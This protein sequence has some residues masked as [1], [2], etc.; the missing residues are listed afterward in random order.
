MSRITSVVLGASF[1]DEGKGKVVDWLCNKAA[2]DTYNRDVLV[3]RFSGGSQCGHT[4]VRNG[5]RHIHG[6]FP[7]GT[8]GAFKGYLTEDCVFSPYHAYNEYELLKEKVGGII[9]LQIHPLA[10]LNTHLDVAF[11]RVRE[12]ILGHGSCGMGVGAAMYRNEHTPYKFRV[13]DLLHP[14]V[15]TEKLVALEDFYRQE[16]AKFTEIGRDTLIKR[17]EDF[18]TEKKKALGRW[19]VPELVEWVRDAFTIAPLDLNNFKGHLIF[20]GSQGV[21]LDQGH[22]MFP[23]C[24]YANTTSKNIAKY[25]DEQTETYY[26]TRSYLTRHGNGPFP[27]ESKKIAKLVD[28]PTNKPNDWQGTQRYAGLDLSMLDHAFS[29]DGAYNPSLYKNIVVN[30]LD[31]I[32]YDIEA[33]QDGFKGYNIFTSS[34]PTSRAKD[35]ILRD[36]I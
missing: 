16:I 15:Y 5:T 32:D 4:V 13:V 8:L 12:K 6:T 3:V 29:I 23:Y 18:D 19:T 25:L 24:T 10:H 36:N 21:L 33:I 17:L 35:I 22:G 31:Q 26:V 14:S 30:C 2:S 34:V 1:G 11:G 27:Q 20:E 28:D 9:N 7:S